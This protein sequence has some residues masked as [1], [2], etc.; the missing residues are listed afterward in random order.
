MKKALGLAAGL[1]VTALVTVA[2]LFA[3]RHVP[4]LA[5]AAGIR[6]ASGWN[7]LQQDVA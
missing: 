1:A 5:N 6:P 7:P 4:A 3:V 2:V